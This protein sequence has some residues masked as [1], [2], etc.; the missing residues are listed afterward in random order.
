MHHSICRETDLRSAGKRG[1]F[2]EE[3]RDTNEEIITAYIY[4]S[5]LSVMWRENKRFHWTVLTVINT[6]FNCL[7]IYG[8][9]SLAAHFQ[10]SLFDL[11]D[12]YLVMLMVVE[13]FHCISRLTHQT[14]EGR[15]GYPPSP[16]PPWALFPC[17]CFLVFLGFFFRFAPNLL[18]KAVKVEG[19][20]EEGIVRTKHSPE[21][22]N[23]SCQNPHST[24]TCSPHFK[25]SSACWQMYWFKILLFIWS[26]L[27][28]HIV[29]PCNQYL[30]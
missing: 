20:Q 4:L 10:K 11:F 24:D 30:S 16:A 18:R 15:T 6:H 22:L 2:V 26:L 1:T 12:L 14:L 3:R 23:V 17:T 5:L 19:T 7:Q 28:L 13:L 25:T 9:T 8:W 29:H 21:Q 27:C